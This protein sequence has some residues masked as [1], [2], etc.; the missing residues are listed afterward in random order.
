MPA[1]T[2]FLLLLFPGKYKNFFIE[3]DAFFEVVW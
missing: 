1:K 2:T 3:G